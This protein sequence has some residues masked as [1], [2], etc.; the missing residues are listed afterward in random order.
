MAHISADRVKET[1]TSTGTGTLTLAGAASGFR[2]FSS[3]MTNND[4]CWYCIADQGGLGWETGLGTYNAGTLARSAVLSSSNANNAVAFAAGTKD[5]FITSPADMNLTLDA[6]LVMTLPA[7]VN[8]VSV[9]T[10][11][12]AVF[13]RKIAGRM[14]LKMMG[15]SGVDNPLQPALFGNRMV[16]YLPS[17][18]TTGTG[19]GTSLGPA[20]TSNGTVSH[21][22]PSNA[23]PAM[24]NQ[25]KR[26]RWANVVTTANQFLGPRMNAASEQQFWRGDGSSPGLGG[27]FYAARF[28]VELW[29]ASTCRIFLGLTGSPNS[30]PVISDTVTLQSCGLWHDTTDS[31][32]TLNFL[33]RSAT[34]TSKQ[35]ITLANAITAMSGYD[36]YMFCPPNGSTLYWRLDDILNNVTYEGNT[37]TNLPANNTFMQAQASMSNGTANITATTVALGLAGLY[38]E[39]D[40]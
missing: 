11:D 40:H 7:T 21:P 9:A 35:T 6:G 31:N 36:F 27:F 25:M 33:T 3:V 1:T 28:T 8:P 4:T 5:V 38:C 26:T 18:G 14:L 20:W 37:A 15:P 32:T 17:T 22:T 2:A 13:A 30:G 29:A 39:S 23:A 12:L 24:T 10:D 16:M 19:S 34:A